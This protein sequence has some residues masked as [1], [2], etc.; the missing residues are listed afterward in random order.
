M[1]GGLILLVVMALALGVILGE[2]RRHHRRR[3]DLRHIAGPKV[4]WRTD[5]EE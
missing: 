3:A 4:W 5:R 1:I 2:A